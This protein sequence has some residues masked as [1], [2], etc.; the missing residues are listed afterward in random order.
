[1]SS[2]DSSEHIN[3]KEEGHIAVSLRKLQI[4]AYLRSHILPKLKKKHILQKK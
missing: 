2:F 4:A 3:E 1:M